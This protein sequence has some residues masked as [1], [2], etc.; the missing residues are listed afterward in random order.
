[1]TPVQQIRQHALDNYNN[2][3]DYI[4][5]CYTDAEIQQEYLD[6]CDGD[7]TKAMALIQEVADYRNEQSEE[8]RREI[9]S[10]TDIEEETHMTKQVNYGLHETIEGS[11]RTLS[12][13]VTMYAIYYSDWTQVLEELTEFYASDEWIDGDSFSD[14]HRDLIHR[15]NMTLG[16]IKE[17]G[18]E[19]RGV[20]IDVD[21]C[22]WASHDDMFDNL[23]AA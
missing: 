20:G 5:E 12:D 21:L 14:A 23:E 3:W 1:M 11:H 15:R 13:A 7:V 9:E 4:V 8:A 17:V 22:D 10:N 16:L 6:V 18:A 2:G 19:L